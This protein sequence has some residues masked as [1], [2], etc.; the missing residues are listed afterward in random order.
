MEITFETGTW[1]LIFKSQ[2]SCFFK[3]KRFGRNLGLAETSE[4]LKL[5]LI[6]FIGYVSTKKVQED[7][8]K[9]HQP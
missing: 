7:D 4:G 3:A 5:N 1:T 6:P 9:H 2:I 8:T